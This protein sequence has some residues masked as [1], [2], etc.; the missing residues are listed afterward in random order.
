MPSLSPS[1]K[2]C[3]KESSISFAVSY[4][5]TVSRFHQKYQLEHELALS[6]LLS[7]GFLP[8]YKPGVLIA[9]A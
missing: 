2:Y 3:F 5:F 8:G 6:Q 4:T 7:L 9:T 1:P